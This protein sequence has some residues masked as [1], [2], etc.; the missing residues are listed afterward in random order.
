MNT[1]S[2]IY[3]LQT[4]VLLIVFPPIGLKRIIVAALREHEVW[5]VKQEAGL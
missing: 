5:K 2:I 4:L 1:V 3:W